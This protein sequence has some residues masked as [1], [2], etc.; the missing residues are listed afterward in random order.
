MSSDLLS[1]D[2]LTGTIREAAEIIPCGLNQ[3]YE[4]AKRGEIPTIKIG[5]KKIVPW[6]KFLRL[7]KGEATAA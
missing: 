2:K 5:R 7:L 3:A 6:Q 1:P 4:A